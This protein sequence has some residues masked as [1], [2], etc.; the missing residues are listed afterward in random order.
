MRSPAQVLATVL[1][2]LLA[3]VEHILVARLGPSRGRTPWP[4]PVLAGLELAG[5]ETVVD[6]T[7]RGAAKLFREMS[8]SD[9]SGVML[10]P[11]AADAQL[12]A[13]A[14]LQLAAAS[15]VRLWRP[16]PVRELGVFCSPGEQWNL[17]LLRWAHPDV[18]CCLWNTDADLPEEWRRREG[19]IAQFL[20]QGY[21]YMFLPRAEVAPDMPG[22]LLLEPGFEGFWFWPDLRPRLFMRDTAAWC[23]ACFHREE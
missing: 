4:D 3:G 17:D 19:S 18:A 1:P 2:P 22:E 5:L 11:D 16:R 23:A 6:L 15:N 13:E 12:P 7:N 20:A 21:D 14:R 9:R 8:V 10:F